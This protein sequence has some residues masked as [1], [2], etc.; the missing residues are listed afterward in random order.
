MD[1]VTLATGVRNLFDEAYYE[2]LN[3]QY[4]PG[5]NPSGDALYE[6]GRRFFAELSIRF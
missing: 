4:N 5:V 6:P 1:G 3:R 2:H